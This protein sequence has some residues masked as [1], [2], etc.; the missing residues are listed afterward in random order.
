MR[1]KIICLL[2]IVLGLRAFGQ[3]NVTMSQH[4]F[5]D[6]IN[7][8]IGGSTAIVLKTND[9]LALAADTK[10]VS[11]S[12]RMEDAGRTNKIKIIGRF[13]YTNVG[14]Y[15]DSKGILDVD[16]I[17]LEASKKSSD[18]FEIHQIVV[19]EITK[20]VPAAFADIKSTNPDCYNNFILNKHNSISIAFVGL[21]KNKLTI[22]ATHFTGTDTS[23]IHQQID[24][25]ASL[26]LLLFGA[27]SEID[28]Y[29]DNNTNPLRQGLESGM[30]FLVGLEA[31]KQPDYVGLPIDLLILDKN[32]FRWIRHNK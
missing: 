1:N 12:S 18:L 8:Y 6:S 26:G 24:T 25:S 19:D 29:L 10:L 22:I 28:N 21:V 23:C 16:N 7:M 20:K 4:I 15:K 9:Y 2:S 27:H 17:V 30:E 11:I 3:N 5:S 32:G 31:K 14:L 13:A